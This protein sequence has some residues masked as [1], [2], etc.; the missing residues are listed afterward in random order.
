[1][2]RVMDLPIREGHKHRLPTPIKEE[3]RA[4]MSGED[5]GG[6]GANSAGALHTLSSILGEISVDYFDVSVSDPLVC[7]TLYARGATP[8]F[9]NRREVPYNAIIPY[10]EDRL[11]LKGPVLLRYTPKQEHYKHIMRIVSGSGA[12]LINSPKDS[13]YVEA[14]LNAALS[15]RIPTY[16]VA[17][18]SLEREF[19]EKKMLPRGP[20]VFNYNDAI[21]I[22]GDHIPSTKDD[23]RAY[24]LEL[25][26]ALCKDGK[27]PHPLYLTLGP[28]GVYV[29]TD[30]E[31]I[32]VGLKKE[33]QPIANQARREKGYAANGAGDVFAAGIVARP[34]FAQQAMDIGE[35]AMQASADAVRYLGYS[36]VTP[37]AFSI[38]RKPLR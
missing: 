18:P 24:A 22:F 2:F 17:T 29:L 9:F 30:E 11:V 1:M 15:R 34:L 13:G 8:H 3:V 27:S 31:R 37:S 4:I 12:L 20:S 38:D 23:K 21:D 36:G 26:T 5:P 10:R 6:G 14:F 33:E 7:D 25:L 19:I 28:K 16:F 35:L 32:H